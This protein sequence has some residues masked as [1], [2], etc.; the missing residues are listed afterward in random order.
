LKP[1]QQAL[2][3]HH[4]FY[5]FTTLSFLLFLASVAIVYRFT[6]RR[7]R[8]PVLF[9]AS[10]LLYW[11]WSHK[12]ALLL[13]ALTAAIYFAAL[14]IEASR[15][16]KIRQLC[17]Y[18][19]ISSLVAILCVFKA[20]PYLRAF[21]HDVPGHPTLELVVPLGIS[22]YTFKLL[23]YV[24]DVF[25]QRAS[26]ERRFVAFAA[27]VAFFPQIVAGPIQRPESF[28]PQMESAP[29]A[30]GRAVLLGAQRILLG[31]F[32]KFMVA[33]HLAILVNFIYGHLRAHGTPLILG[34][35]A[36]PLQMYAD[37]SAL[38][39]I[40][41]GAA[42]LLG[43][44]SPE[45][46]EAPFAA[47]S[48]SEYWRRWHITLTQ[49]LVDYV[50]TPLCMETRNL[51]KAGLVLSIFVNMV[52]IGLWHGF[53]AAFAAFGLIHAVY[54]SIDALTT[55]TRKRYYKQ[56][57]GAKR[58]AKWI[59]P[60]LTFHLVGVPFVF[61]RAE[62]VTGACYLLTHL[63]QGISGLST[64]FSTLWLLHGTAILAG[65]WGYAVAE[66]ADWY[67]RHNRHGELVFALPRWGR[68]SVYTS[69]A[70][71]SVILLLLIAGETTGASP[72]LYAIF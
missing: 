65:V 3:W 24:I 31:F 25:W 32:K 14:A 54:L 71:C 7:W 63:L 43:I 33:D 66:L 35:Y 4:P 70:T 17:A 46:F 11:S 44:E 52:L 20:S 61:F 45:N 8:A 12:L 19:S 69:T 16:Q 23:S 5:R 18:G 64:D 53:L 6:P 28:L 34:F 21:L 57:P 41:V 39:D 50:F 51:G 29:A 36:Y 72:F 22:Y 42:W 60:V 27:Y 10:Y 40:A 30:D 58:L 55:K 49:W 15:S 13:L 62:S 9:V 2:A 1:L 67:R 38:T 37:F 59:G 56:H 68:W 48:V 26:A 47:P